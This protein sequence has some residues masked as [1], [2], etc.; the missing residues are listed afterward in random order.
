ML[1]LAS[2]LALPLAFAAAG[3]GV[4]ASA[5]AAV[6]KPITCELR[7]ANAGGAPAL[8]A[9]AKADA[10]IAASYQ[11]DFNAVSAGSNAVTSEGDDVALAAGETVLNT[12]TFSPG[13]KYVAKLTV[14]WA[15]GSTSCA[16]KS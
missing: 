13:A 2:L 15:G 5:E 11:L 10:A 8:M 16:A 4:G 1:K 7:L 3:L 6:A 12:A 9:V 14:S